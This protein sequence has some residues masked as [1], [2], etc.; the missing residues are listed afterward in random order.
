MRKHEQNAFAI[1]SFLY[2][3][4]KLNKYAVYICYAA[5]NTYAGDAKWN[6]SAA[7]LRMY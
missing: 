4:N 1:F 2:Y 3:N 5:K 6:S 7:F